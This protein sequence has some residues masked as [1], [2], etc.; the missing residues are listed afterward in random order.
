MNDFSAENQRLD[1][2]V[3]HI[4]RFVTYLLQLGIRGES[5]HGVFFGRGK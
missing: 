4:A 3:T 2:S 5:S 1:L